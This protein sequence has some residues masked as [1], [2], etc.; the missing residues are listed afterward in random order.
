MR[1]TRMTLS[2]PRMLARK[3]SRVRRLSVMKVSTVR[4]GAKTT[5]ARNVRKR[6]SMMT[7]GLRMQLLVHH[8]PLVAMQT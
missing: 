6:P 1:M 8:P 3:V 7:L 4:G 5:K 2:R